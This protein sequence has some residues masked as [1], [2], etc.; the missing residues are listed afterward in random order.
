MGLRVFSVVGE[1]LNFGARRMP[2]IMRVA[3][4]PVI[5]LLIVD[6]ATAF[7]LLWAVLDRPIS[8]SDAHTWIAVQRA[9]QKILGQILALFVTQGPLAISAD[10]YGVLGASFIVQFILVASFM[11]PLIRYAGLRELPAPGVLKLDFGANQIRYMFAGLVSI[12]VMATVV[13]GPVGA[14]AF[15][16]LKYISAALS[17]TYASFPD[18]E[19]LHTI[20]IVSAQQALAKSGG[21]WFFERGVPLIAAAPFALAMWALLIW[22]FRP[23]EQGAGAGGYLRTAIATLFGSAAFAGLFWFGFHLLGQIGHK[24]LI[25]VLLT[26]VSPLLTAAFALSQKLAADQLAIVT[27]IVMFFYYVSLRI[28]PY[29]AVVVCRSSMAP[30]GTLS[31]TRGWNIVRMFFI[32]FLISA[33]LSVIVFIINKYVFVLVLDVARL[34]Y[35]ATASATKLVHHGSEAEWVRPFW[36][37]VWNGFKILANIFWTFFFYGVIAG[38]FGRL[39]RESETG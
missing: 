23:R 28:T 26:I 1:A 35:Q 34:L 4:L 7:G 33:V 30:A 9:V 29:Q 22:H 20:E 19:S 3:W 5:L 6:M 13:I 21:L 37:W 25:A 32:T 24:T 16:A 36:S 10:I 31:V 39:Y 15:Y 27:V 8:F 11:T 38:L 12:L 14:T 17:Q 2:T 18:P